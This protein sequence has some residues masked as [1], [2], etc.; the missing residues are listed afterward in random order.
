MTF[1]SRRGGYVSF[2]AVKAATGLTD[3]VLECGVEISRSGMALCPFHDDWRPSLSIRGERWHC[4]GC[5]AHGDVFDWCERFHRMDTGGAL[6]YL[7][8]RAGFARVSSGGAAAPVPTPEEAAARRRRELRDRFFSW[9]HDG[10]GKNAELIR[11]L[12]SIIGALIKTPEDLAT[13]TAEYLYDK[14]TR[15]EGAKETLWDRDWEVLAE[16]YREETIGKV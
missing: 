5:G 12:D 9:M 15:A 16:Y 7:A 8:A 2:A 11:R 6:R 13:E 14:R 1:D 10:R 3:L 4:F